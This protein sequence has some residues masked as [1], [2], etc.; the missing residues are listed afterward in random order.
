MKLSTFAFSRIAGPGDIRRAPRSCAVPAVAAGI[1]R[2]R[3]DQATRKIYFRVEP[4]LRRREF[5]VESRAGSGPA[6]ISRSARGM[7]GFARIGRRSGWAAPRREPGIRLSGASDCRSWRVVV[8]TGPRLSK[9]SRSARGMN[10]FAR[11]GRWSEWAAGEPRGGIRVPGAADRR[12]CMVVARKRTPRLFATLRIPR[13]AGRLAAPQVTR[14]SPAF[15]RLLGRRVAQARRKIRI[16][17]R[18]DPR[19]AGPKMA[20][21][22]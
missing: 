10:G 2:L 22:E 16:K 7:N 3:A 19:S 1:S 9:I 6:K 21:V 11:I 15:P 13:P 17:D 5:K 8:R 12:S 18:P 4:D 14:I 20:K